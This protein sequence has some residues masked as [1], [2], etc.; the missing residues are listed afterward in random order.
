MARNMVSLYG[1]ND[2]IGPVSFGDGDHDVF[3]GHDLV[4]RPSYSGHTARVI[5]EEV[6]AMLTSLYDEAYQML[7]DNRVTLDRIVDA[8]AADAVGAD[9]ARGQRYEPDGFGAGHVGDAGDGQQ[10]GGL[11]AIGVGRDDPPVGVGEHDGLIARWRCCQ[12]PGPVGLI[13]RKE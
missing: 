11:G 13:R 6:I 3:L 8:D 5:D 9:A 2:R 12:A 10:V 4:Q 1:M 7:S